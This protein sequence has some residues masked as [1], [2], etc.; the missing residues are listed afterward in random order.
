MGKT[1]NAPKPPLRLA[2]RGPHVIQQCVGPPHAPPQTAAPTV[3]MA[4]LKFALKKRLPVDRFPNP[5]AYLIPGLVRPMMPN[6]IRI[7][8]AVFHIT[9][10]R[11]THVGPSN[12]TDRPT[13][14][15]RESLMI[16]YSGLNA[17]NLVN[18]TA[19]WP[20]SDRAINRIAFL[21]LYRLFAVARNV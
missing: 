12:P 9:L 11:P 3:A 21:L 2:R 19:P 10:D 13:D 14:R 6:G 18:V 17:A 8:Y 16:N 1:P 15:P 20:C 4:R 7:R 5:T